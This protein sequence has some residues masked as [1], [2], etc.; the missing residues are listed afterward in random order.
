VRKKGRKERK[1]KKG[2]VGEELAN[3]VR[4]RIAV[5]SKFFLLKS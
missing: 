1:R 4:G 3:H 5:D 2:E